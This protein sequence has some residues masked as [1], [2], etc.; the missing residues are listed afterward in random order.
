MSTI[1][2]KVMASVGVIYTARRLASMTALKVYALALS[3]V[4]LVAFVSVSNVLHNFVD[5]MSGGVG[6][7]F[8][9]SFVAVTSTTLPVQAVLMVGVLALLSLAADMARSLKEQKAFIA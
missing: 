2:Q 8:S 4:G 1:E 3:C 9:Y 6:K 5:A 7:V